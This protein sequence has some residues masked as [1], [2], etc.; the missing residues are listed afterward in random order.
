VERERNCDTT[1]VDEFPLGQNVKLSRFVEHDLNSGIPDVN[2][3]EYDYVLLLDVIEHLN[4]PEV[5]FD[6]LRDAM[7]IALKRTLSSARRTLGLSSCGSCSS[8]GNS[9]EASSI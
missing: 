4:V 3:A 7:N 2:I 9:T 6:R 5:F 8:W 1:G